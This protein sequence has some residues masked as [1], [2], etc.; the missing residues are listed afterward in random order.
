MIGD[1]PI[2][3][4]LSARVGTCHYTV[5]NGYNTTNWLLTFFSNTLDLDDA[6][7]PT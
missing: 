6:T 4:L 5:A 1:M 3:M 2:V 7:H